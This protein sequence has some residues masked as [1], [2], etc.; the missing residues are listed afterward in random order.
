LELHVST[1]GRAEVH[2][3]HAVGILQ[4]DKAMIPKQQHHILDPLQVDMLPQVCE[5]PSQPV[6]AILV[7]GMPVSSAH[8]RFLIEDT[9]RKQ[10]L[11]MPTHTSTLFGA[12]IAAS[13]PAHLLMNTLQ[14]PS[15]FSALSRDISLNHADQAV[16][17]RSPWVLPFP[18]HVFPTH[19]RESPSVCTTQEPSDF[20]SPPL[21]WHPG[22]GEHHDLHSSSFGYDALENFSPLSSLDG[23]L[24]SVAAFE[25]KTRIPYEKCESWTL[26]EVLGLQPTTSLNSFMV[27]ARGA[28]SNIG[29]PG[30]WPAVNV[31][32]QD[33][34]RAFVSRDQVPSAAAFEGSFSMLME[35][36]SLFSDQKPLIT[37]SSSVSSVSQTF[38]TP[39]SSISSVRQAFTTT[40]STCT[41]L[42]K[43]ATTPPPLKTSTVLGQDPILNLN[44]TL[45]LHDP[46][47]P[48]SP[49]T[50]FT[51]NQALLPTP[52]PPHTTTTTTKTP[53]PPRP[54][55]LLGPNQM[56]KRNGSI[57]LIRHRCPHCEKPFT[58]KSHL[59]SHIVM[60][61]DRRDH[62]CK[63]CSARF[64]RRHDLKRHFLTA[65]L[66][67]KK[68]SVI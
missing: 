38:S 5:P 18:P 40:P 3:L 32:L 53:R 41:I 49:R 33:D 16:F 21:S 29:P 22:S 42:Q 37:P 34:Q 48:Q 56:Q 14:Y 23:S 24:E 19:R 6:I 45:P 66:G 4:I 62:G 12:P 63:E 59:L 46:T 51:Q 50:L 27:N 11:T 8:S 44:A 13:D 61:S 2:S 43:K 17:N 36:T 54:T 52:P 55:P 57:A 9:W 47:T 60:H 20:P 64:A 10:Q 67:R 28:E 30:L 39:S 25:S 26:G 7:Q 65:H 15:H 35:D 31:E 68:V 58:R 1:P